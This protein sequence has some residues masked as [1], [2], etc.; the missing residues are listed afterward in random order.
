MAESIRLK[1]LLRQRHWQP[2]RTFCSEYDR[3]AKEIDPRLIG[4]WPSRTQFN[5]WLAGDIKSL[6]YP[7]HCRVLEK[8][9]AG[10]VVEELFQPHVD[11]G[12][13]DAHGLEESTHTALQPAQGP[14]RRWSSVARD[15]AESSQGFPLSR[16]AGDTSGT[17]RFYKDFVEIGRDWE[18]LFNGSPVLDLAMMYGSTWRNTYHKQ[19]RALAQRPDGRIR[20]VLPDCAKESPLVPLYA[21]TLRIGHDEFRG[22]V[23]E[24]VADFRSIEPRHHVEIYFT[25][26][27]FRHAL[28]MFAEH[29]ILALYSLSGERIPTPALQVSSGGLLNF[30]R[31]DFDHLLRQSDRDSDRVER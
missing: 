16:P 30:L 3:A 18:P 2:Y 8:M 1:L 11:E 25:K 12:G 28:F 15:I 17:R 24:A 5:R 26:T 10:Y 14:A 6:P 21:T 23:S 19:L 31:L 29:A 9:F 20:V 7:D 22:K 4:T 13:R 27:A